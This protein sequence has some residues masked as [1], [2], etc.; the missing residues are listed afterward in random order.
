MASPYWTL[1]MG[2]HLGS[3]LLAGKMFAFSHLPA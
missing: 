3:S 2:I 1:V